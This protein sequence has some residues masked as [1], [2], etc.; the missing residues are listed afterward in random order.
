MF[1]DPL[2]RLGLGP[3][4]GIYNTFLT[5]VLMF[6]GFT[7]AHRIQQ[8]A[9]VKGI[10][11]R[12]YLESLMAVSSTPSRW[13]DPA[14]HEFVTADLGTWVLMIAVVLPIT[15]V[16]WFPLFR[17]RAYI[18][19]RKLALSKEFAVQRARADEEGDEQEAHRH[20]ERMKLLDQANIWPNGD[21]VAQ[22]FITAMIVIW[23]G[24]IFPIVFVSVALGAFGVLELIRFGAWV[25]EKLKAR[26]AAAA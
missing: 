3:L 19:R 13:L 7:A 14:V 24:S 17:M 16:C 18:Q 12:S 25:H 1:D 20:L 4:G 6:G 5:L 22:R 11:I 23:L 9:L 21:A 10:S 2:K 8:V 15:L 26:Q